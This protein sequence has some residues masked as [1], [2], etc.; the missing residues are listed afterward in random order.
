MKRAP[1]SRIL[2]I[3]SGNSRSPVVM[4]AAKLPLC[5]PPVA[6]PSIKIKMSAPWPRRTLLEIARSLSA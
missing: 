6:E 1:L 4:I 5:V 3:V 2:V